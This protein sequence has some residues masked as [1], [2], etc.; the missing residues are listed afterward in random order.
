MIP[1]S[2]MDLAWLE[3][4]PISAALVVWQGGMESG[5]AVADVLT[6]AVTPCG[7][8]TDTISYRYEDHPSAS[9]FL[10]NDANVYAE[11]IYVGYRYFETFAQD[12]VQF[13]FGFGLSYT[14]FALENVQVKLCGDTVRV[15]ATV[16]NTAATPARKWCRCTAPRPR[17]F[18]AKLPGCCAPMKRPSCSSPGNARC[19][20]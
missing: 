2:V 19:W 12:K 14:T 13:P 7:K 8:L 11:D 17:A 4:Y 3:E 6:G 10:G 15:K 1:G 9:N 18:W 16:K 5:N 20:I